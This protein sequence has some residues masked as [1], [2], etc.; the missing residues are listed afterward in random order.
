MVSSPLAMTQEKNIIQV[1]D[2]KI[3][4]LL[5]N[6]DIASPVIPTTVSASDVCSITCADVD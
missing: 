3:E 1:R 6:E 4:Q 5:T 2:N